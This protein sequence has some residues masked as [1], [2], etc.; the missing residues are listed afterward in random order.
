MRGT[1]L[2][3]FSLCSF[4]QNAVAAQVLFAEHNGSRVRMQIGEAS[5]DVSTFSIYYT[6][7]RPALRKEGV[8]SE[9]LLFEG[10]IELET[11]FVSG[12]ART[13]KFG[14]APLPYV[15]LGAYSNILTLNQTLV[16]SGPA[17]VF[18][19]V[20]CAFD[21]FITGDRAKLIFVPLLPGRH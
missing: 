4:G 7:P 9:T 8:V 10:S 6:D 3:L 14:C 21:H 1:L 12:Q 11:G 5:E 2:V 17:P 13:F 15:V 19:K 16:L 20:G 18:N